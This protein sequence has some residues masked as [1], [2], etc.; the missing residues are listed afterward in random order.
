MLRKLACAVPVLFVLAAT[1]WA[2]PGS[3]DAEKRVAADVQSRLVAWLGPD[4][5]T[6]QV[7]VVGSRAFLIGVVEERVTQELADEVALAS[8]GV[9]SS[10]NRVQARKADRHFLDW[11]RDEGHDTF[12]EIRVKRALQH[13]GLAFA[14]AIEVETVD[15]VVS[16]RGQVESLEQRNLAVEL[17]GKVEGA[18]KVLDL[19]SYV[20]P[21]KPAAAG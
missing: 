4:A 3:S 11:L 17:A 7:T 5:Q 18:K 19:L 16:L 15:G 1:A 10:H 2:Q 8:T 21:A 13:E 12:L 20:V 14:R 6:I 9:A